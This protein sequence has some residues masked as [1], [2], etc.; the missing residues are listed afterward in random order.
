MNP[1]YLCARLFVLVAVVL[2]PLVSLAAPKKNEAE[3]LAMLKSPEPQKVIDAL[4]RLPNL[5]PNSTTAVQEIRGLLGTRTSARGFP[6][7]I[8]TRKAARALGNYGATLGDEDI[9]VFLKL[10]RSASVDDVMDGLK[11]L[12]G[13]KQ[14]VESEQKIAAEVALLL[15]DKEIHIVRDAIR[16]LG[17]LGNKDTIPVLEPFLKHS[18][19]DVK[20]DAR[21]A[22][23]ALQKKAAR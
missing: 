7:N 17:A 22:I 10:I 12:R 13:L 11:A 16:T 2:I 15:K 23:A 14:P 3:L 21:A 20:A 9:Q 19:L 5:Y 6:S 1:P 8:I 4:D 18:R